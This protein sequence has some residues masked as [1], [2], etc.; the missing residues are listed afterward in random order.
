MSETVKFVERIFSDDNE[1][2]TDPYSLKD[3]IYRLNLDST[4]TWTSVILNSNVNVALFSPLWSPWVPH[5]EILLTCFLAISHNH[6]TMIN[7]DSTV[8]R[9]KYATR[10]ELK[11]KGISLNRGW[12]RAALRYRSFYGL[13]TVWRDSFETLWFYHSLWLIIGATCIIGQIWVVRVL[14]HAIVWGINKWTYHTSPVTTDV[15]VL[16]ITWAVN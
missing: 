13:C 8:L 7:L 14:L 5:N 9:I 10:I 12:D 3:W 15:S 4:N 2:K 16:F 6:H 11:N 1:G